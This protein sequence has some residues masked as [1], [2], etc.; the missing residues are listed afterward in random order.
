MVEFTCDGC[1]KKATVFATR[2]GLWFKPRDWYERTDED[3]TQTAC[4]RECAS[5]RSR[6]VPEKPALCCRSET[7]AKWQLSAKTLQGD[8]MAK[9]KKVDPYKTLRVP[10]GADKAT[11]KRAYRKRA[12]E[13][14]P[15]IARDDGA[16][17]REVHRCYKLLTDDRARERFDRYGDEQPAPPP[18]AAASLLAGL[19]QQLTLQL[20][21]AGKDPAT[22]DLVAHLETMRRKSEQ[23]V[24]NNRAGLAKAERYWRVICG[25]FQ[26][27]RPENLFET[28]AAEQLAKVMAQM[29]QLELS[30]AAH[31]SARDLLRDYSYRHDA[32]QRTNASG[33]PTLLDSFKTTIYFRTG[34]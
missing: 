25:R 4:S 21:Q 18:S 15:D 27:D 14:H 30:L 3:G 7:C 9:A 19:F 20:F 31:Q 5:S 26:T 2:D 12:K 23:V 8:P 13:T 29:G 17:F 33:T 11:I 24:T 6:I 16:E 28:M 10:K 32:S 22:E 34:T 1:G